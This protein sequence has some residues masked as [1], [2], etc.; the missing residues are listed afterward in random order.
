MVAGEARQ[1]QQIEQ[2]EPQ[3]QLRRRFDQRE[4]Q[5]GRGVRQQ[6]QE[7]RPHQPQRERAYKRGSSPRND[8]KHQSGTAGSQLF[9]IDGD[10]RDPADR[11]Q[12][13]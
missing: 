4:G 9:R 13:D 2:R 5:R 11:E 12:H 7:H 6:R 10:R 3:A 8:H 1:R